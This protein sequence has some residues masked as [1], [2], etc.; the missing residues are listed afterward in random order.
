MVSS[1]QSARGSFVVVAQISKPMTRALTA[2][3]TGIAITCAGMDLRS[4]LARKGTL[5]AVAPVNEGIVIAA[6]SRSAIGGRFCDTTYKL[7]EVGGK[8]PTAVAVAGIGIVFTRPP[9]GVSDLCHWLN[10]AKRVMDVETFAKAWLEKHPGP[11][12]RQLM[13]QLGS[14]S[15]DLVRALVRFSPGA[16]R[17]Y[18]GNNLYTVVAARYERH[19]NLRYVG[20]VGIRFGPTSG[21][22]EVTDY[23]AWQYSPDSRGEAFNFGLFDYVRDHVLRLGRPWAQRYLA[24]APGNRTV[25]QISSADAAAALENLIDAAS[26][27]TSV[28]P[29]DGGTGIGGPVDVLLLGSEDKPRKIRW[30]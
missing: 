18:A 30:K 25:K 27:T 10:G 11:L 16:P 6:D 15:L 23:E 1:R 26:R 4:T 8:E 17:A 2:V 7:I 22:P 20:V 28:V 24:F 19:S 3:L 9:A 14:E 29:P 13:G 21:S 5:I 12:T